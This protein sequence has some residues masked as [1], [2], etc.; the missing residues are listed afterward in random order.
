MVPPAWLGLIAVLVVVSKAGVAEDTNAIAEVREVD[1]A[2]I[3]G[4]ITERG[5]IDV[6]TGAPEHDVS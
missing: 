2:G 3:A 5:D 4:E 1:D 6:T